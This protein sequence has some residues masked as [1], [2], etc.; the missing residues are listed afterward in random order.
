MS[1][2]MVTRGGQ[3]RGGDNKGVDKG[4]R[5]QQQWIREGGGNKWWI[6]E[7]GNKWWIRKGGS[8]QPGVDKG[9]RR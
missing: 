8:G 2:G 3:G 1:K 9:V 4:R 5:G 7:G 6:R